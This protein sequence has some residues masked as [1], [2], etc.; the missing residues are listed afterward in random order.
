MTLYTAVV[1]TA[2]GAM[3]AVGSPCGL[4]ALEFGQARREALLAGRLA[5][6]FAGAS[7]SEGENAAIDAVRG[8]LA[9]FF[10]HRFDD[11][12]TVP[13]DLRG[14]ELELEVWRELLAIPPGERDTYGAIAVRLGRPH[15]ARAVGGAV[16]RNPVG[17]L[18]PCHRVVGASGALTGYGGGLDKKRW[19][20]R[21]EAGAAWGSQP[22]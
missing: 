16:G 17:I 2:L 10:A 1:K 14:S 3:T 8:W 7:V 13:L 6:Y 21:H 11:P 5:R 15:G 18:V 19:L 4:V 12:A 9:H 20:L 22:A